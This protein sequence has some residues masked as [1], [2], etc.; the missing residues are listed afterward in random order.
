MLAQLIENN[1]MLPH[2]SIPG[3][4]NYRFVDRRLFEAA[5][6]PLKAID[7]HN[8]ARIIPHGKY[9]IASMEVIPPDTLN[10]V[11][12]SHRLEYFL[13]NASENKS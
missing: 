13:E 1:A 12:S 4:F 3:A 7:V 2:P 10:K 8:G 11:F 5:I 9:S 6:R